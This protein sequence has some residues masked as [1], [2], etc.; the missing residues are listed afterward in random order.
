[1][2]TMLMKKAYANEKWHICEP[3]TT[4]NAITMFFQCILMLVA[5]AVML[6][7]FG[8]VKLAAIP[9]AILKNLADKAVSESGIDTGHDTDA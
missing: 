2:F 9:F 5:M 7:V 1:M 4:K 6:L 3:G 8:I